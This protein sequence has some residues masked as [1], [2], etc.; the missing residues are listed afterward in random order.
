MCAFKTCDMC[1]DDDTVSFRQGCRMIWWRWVR[2]P[3]NDAT[4]IWNGLSWLRMWINW[5]WI[6]N[7][8]ELNEEVKLS[9]K[10]VYPSLRRSVGIYDHSEDIISK[11]RSSNNRMNNDE[12]WQPFYSFQQEGFHGSESTVLSSAGSVCVFCKVSVCSDRQGD[13]TIDLKE[14]ATVVGTFVIWTRPLALQSFLKQFRFEFAHLPC[15]I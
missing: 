11:T 15:R 2:D 13:P 9:W 14:E 4:K 10:W 12:R 5:S 3:R 7:S 1:W 6:I 8:P